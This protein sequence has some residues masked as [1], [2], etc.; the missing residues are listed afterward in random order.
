MFVE[1]QVRQGRVQVM[2]NLNEFW[3]EDAETANN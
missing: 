3:D 1:S 2:A